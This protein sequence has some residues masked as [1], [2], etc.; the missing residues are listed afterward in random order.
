MTIGTQYIGELTEFTELVMRL[1]E[2]EINLP[3][4]I[5]GT[6]DNNIY[7]QILDII[8]DCKKINN[9]RLIIPYVTSSGV[10]SRPYINKLYANGGQVRINSHFKKSL[11]LIGGYVCLL[12]FSY[13][14]QSSFGMKTKFEGCMLTDDISTVKQI[15]D[16]FIQI[17]N[18]SLPLTVNGN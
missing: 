2:N 10:I 9:C 3:I 6:F 15:Q 4:F 12:S 5:A 7:R 14:Y 17:W 11:L 8:L 18:E 1:L 13:K 16:D